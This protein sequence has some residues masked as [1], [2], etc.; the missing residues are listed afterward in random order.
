LDIPES[1][2]PGLYAARFTVAAPKMS[3]RTLRDRS[4]YVP[5]VVRAPWDAPLPTLVVVPF[6]AYVARNR[7]PVDGVTGRSLETGYT[8]DGRW[9]FTQR[10]SAVSFDRPFSGNGLPAHF[11]DDA[12]LAERLSVQADFATSVDLHSG[13]VDPR[14]YE[15]VLFSS[16][17]EYWSPE[18]LDAVS[19][20]AAAGTDVRWPNPDSRPTAAI[21][22]GASPD[23]RPHRVVSRINP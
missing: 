18:A 9:S 6:A 20:A 4:A 14:D 17:D 19:A 2:P 13:L 8:A 23:G 16:H 3:L 12:A 5:F 1:W 10:A 22:L 15:S 7:W 11:T 21:R